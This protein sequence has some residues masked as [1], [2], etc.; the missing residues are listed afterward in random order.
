[1]GPVDSGRVLELLNR[2]GRGQRDATHVEIPFPPRPL[3][4]GDRAIASMEG[5]MSG[6]LH[7]APPSII[8][9]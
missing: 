2:F 6:I 4:D 3:P 7:S 1:M 9:T 8:K 5:D